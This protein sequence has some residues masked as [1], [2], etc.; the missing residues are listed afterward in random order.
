[1]VDL[2]EVFGYNAITMKN[3]TERNWNTLNDVKKHI[4]ENVKGE[5]VK[6]FD[7][8]TLVTNKAKYGIVDSRLYVQSNNS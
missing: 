2:F 6:S 4:E 8:A 1:M 7:G 3:W 5:T